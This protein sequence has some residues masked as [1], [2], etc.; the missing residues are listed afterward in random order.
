M[1]APDFTERA[2]PG[3]P[4]ILDLDTHAA[5]V[6]DLGADSKDAA[7][8]PASAVRAGI[9]RQLA[10]QKDSVVGRGMAVQKTG[11]EST[12]MPD[13]ITAAGKGKGARA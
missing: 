4:L 11:D 1:R 13:L 3:A 10:D 5:P 9:R 12:R 8:P 2:L 7:R 6:A